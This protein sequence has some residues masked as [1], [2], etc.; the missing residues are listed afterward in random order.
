M[1]V[2]KGHNVYLHRNE[3]V[4]VVAAVV[5]AAVADRQTS[6]SCSFDRSMAKTRHRLTAAAAVYPH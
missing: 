6:K 4:A 2:C 1:C 5:A 3:T